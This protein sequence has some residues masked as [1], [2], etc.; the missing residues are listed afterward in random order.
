M[1]IQVMG[2]HHCEESGMSGGSSNSMRSSQERKPASR[3]FA[4]YCEG[5]RER[6]RTSQGDFDGELFDE[7][8]ALVLKELKRLEGQ[9]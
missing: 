9:Q 3:G 5:E 2:G 4:Q 1:V 6:R 7:A 8:V